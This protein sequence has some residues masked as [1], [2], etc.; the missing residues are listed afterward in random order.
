MKL[1]KKLTNFN[2]KLG[3]ILSDGLSSMQMFYIVFIC[4]VLPLLFEHPSSLIAW[5]QYL[6]TAILQA[7][8]LPLLG[9]TT[10]K[11]GDVQEKVIKESHSI[12]INQFNE[13]KDM[14]DMLLNEI[15]ERTEHSDEQLLMMEQ[16]K[17]IHEHIHNLEKRKK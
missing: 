4:V 10:K 15:K 11:S 6:S 7:V 1:L 3:V 16:V 17:E 14:H 13:L 8:A 9:F 2:E 5:I 12:L